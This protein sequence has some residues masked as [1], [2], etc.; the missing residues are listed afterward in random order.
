M[1]LDKF[2][3]KAQ[4]LIQNS[5]EV[6]ERFGHQQIEP[7][8]L[9]RLILEQQDGVIPPI[10]GKLGISREQLVRDLDVALERIPKVSG[11]GYGQVYIS[12]RTKVA[13]DHAL[14]EAQQMKDDYVSM[15][16]ILF[17]IL[18]EGGEAHRHPVDERHKK[19]PG[20]EVRQPDRHLKLL[21]TGKKIEKDH[22]LP[23]PTIP[24]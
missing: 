24:E 21:E 7:E 20:G 15:E 5:Q 23:I 12:P 22:R 16:H 2:T 9:M 14:K 17:G 13:L 6:A 1:R 11:A 4:E 10:F 19:N 3:L 18:E 8:H